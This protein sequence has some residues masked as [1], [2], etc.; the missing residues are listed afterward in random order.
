M[1]VHKIEELS[2]IDQ[3]DQSWGSEA[4]GGMNLRQTGIRWDTKGGGRRGKL[5]S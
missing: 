5:V 3:I 4:H 1:A 2:P